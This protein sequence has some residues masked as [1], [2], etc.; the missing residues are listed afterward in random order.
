[1]MIEKAQD[2]TAKLGYK[3]VEFML[4]DIEDIPLE[5][6]IA[7]VVVSN[8]VLNLVPNKQ[9]AFDETYRILKHGGHF[10]ISDVVITGDLPDS[11]KEDA[12]MYAGC[13]SGAI[14][15]DEYLSV[16]EA[17]GFKNLKVQKEKKID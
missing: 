11:I 8:C 10:S 13:V 2:N 16:V 9:K 1:K 5:N 4:G 14:T 17:A 3:N 7:D 6:N 15:R 12:E